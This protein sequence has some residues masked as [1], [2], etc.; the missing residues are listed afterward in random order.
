MYSIFK[1][2]YNLFNNFQILAEHSSVFKTM[3]YAKFHEHG[4]SEIE[5]KDVNHKV[6]KNQIIF[7]NI[8]FRNSWSFSMLSTLQCTELRVG[9][10]FQIA[11]AQI[12]PLAIVN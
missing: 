2:K 9:Y 6:T 4:K 11:K 7:F 8:E 5:L 3:F 1:N 10:S 12:Y